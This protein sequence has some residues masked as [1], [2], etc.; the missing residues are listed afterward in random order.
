MPKRTR[1]TYGNERPETYTQK[2]TSDKIEQSAV[3]CHGTNDRPRSM[4]YHLYDSSSMRRA[5]VMTVK[6]IKWNRTCPGSINIYFILNDSWIMCVRPDGMVRRV[7]MLIIQLRVRFVFFSGFSFPAILI[8]I[9]IFVLRMA[10]NAP[11]ARRWWL[12]RRVGNI[13]FSLLV[14]HNGVRFFLSA[15]NDERICI[16]ATKF[17]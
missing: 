1:R 17:K 3:T 7:E 15:M 10:N 11:C 6:L 4:P 14:W 9:F 16:Y 2:H 12:P 13:F 5:D 8:I